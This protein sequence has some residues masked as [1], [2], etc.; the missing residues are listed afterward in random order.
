MR[1]KTV[2]RSLISGH[3]TVVAHD[4]GP[5]NLRV[6]GH[7]ERRVTIAAVPSVLLTMTD[8]EG[9]DVLVV[10]DAL[11]RVHVIPLDCATVTSRLDL[12]A[13]R[14]RALAASPTE[15]GD[16]VVATS[17]G[18]VAVVDLSTSTSSTVAQ[19]DGPV[20]SLRV[21]EEAL[22]ATVRGTHVTLDWQGSTLSTHA[23]KRPTSR[24]YPRRRSTLVVGPDHRLIAPM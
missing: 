1:S 3:I 20:A 7:R 6:P 16:V 18:M 13:G 17:K 21:S 19:M 9:K 22:I 5:I 24:R 8:R 15:Q 14:V 11:G 23:P 2:V 10:G 12:E 4:D